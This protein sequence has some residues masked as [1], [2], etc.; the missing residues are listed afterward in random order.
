VKTLVIGGGSIGLAAAV[1]CHQ[2]GHQVIV[3]D[4]V[5]FQPV[6]PT[7]EMDA[8]V[9]ALGPKSTGFLSD[10]H[11]WSPDARVC[12]YRSMRVIDAR[13]DARVTFA[14]PKLGHLV[15]AHWVRNQLLKTVGES[16]IQ[17]LEQ[18]V[19]RVDPQGC[20]TLENGQTI[21]SDFVIFA[22]GRQATTAQAS[23]FELMDGGYHQRALVGTLHCEQP[24]DGEAF[25]IFTEQG[26][27]ALLPLPDR[28][29]EHRVSVVWSLPTDAAEA[30]A[31][32]STDM[33]AARL[34]RVSEAARGALG[35]VSGPVWIPISQHALKRDALGC[36]LAIGDTAHGILPLAGLGANLGFAD[37]IALQQALR[38]HPSAA[39]DRLARTVARERCMAHRTVAMVMGL[40]SD[41][42]RSD[43][44]MIQ[45]GRSMALR[46][47]DR[48]P[49]IRSLIQELAG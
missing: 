2:A 27:L 40:F 26:P 1:V 47:A 6:K 4:P 36:L 33:L 19:A 35:F 22:E 23:G 14:D 34:A 13:S 10:I 3:F 5:G 12:C 17:C 24:H 15:E 39:G 9:W 31:Q 44:P 20:V 45:L 16:P 49:M 21:D 28:D 48:H 46:T 32:C 38:S 18:A 37:V 41:V 42:F 8:R 43:Q 29:G 30:L 7:V 25:Q 11:A